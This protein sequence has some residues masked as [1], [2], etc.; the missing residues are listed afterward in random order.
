MRKTIF[1]VG[2]V[3]A[4]LICAPASRAQ[5][6]KPEPMPH[7][8]RLKLVVEELDGA[9]KII[10]NRSYSTDISTKKGSRD[11]SIRAQSRVPYIQDI[12]AN[13]TKGTSYYE[14]GANFDVRDVI[15]VSGQLALSIQADISSYA[16]MEVLE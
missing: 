7:F 6:D 1:T 11:P 10:N 9:G 3:L 14:V 8:Y 5:N 4:L 16:F 12:K 13:G 15:E 2:L